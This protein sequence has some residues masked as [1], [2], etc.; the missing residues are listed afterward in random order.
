[1]GPAEVMSTLQAPV[2]TVMWVNAGKE[3]QRPQGCVNHR[4]SETEN[5]QL[6]L[7]PLP[8]SGQE[9]L[10]HKE[11]PPEN[12]PHPSDWSLI[13]LLSLISLFSYPS[14]A[15]WCHQH[16]SVCWIMQLCPTPLWPYGLQPFRFLCSWNFPGKNTWAG[17]HSLSQ[18]IFLTLE[19][20]LC[21]LL[22]RPILYQWATWEALCSHLP[23]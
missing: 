14:L 2:C 8:K 21:F 18:G 23:P 3:G 22:G 19:S 16:I 9:T 6:G 12:L 20:N 4:H 7:V 15:A 11:T 13:C 5:E 17:C 10:M 1:M